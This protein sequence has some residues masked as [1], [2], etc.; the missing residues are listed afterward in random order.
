MPTKYTLYT[1][2]QTYDKIEIPVI[3]RDYAQGRKEQ[4]TLRNKFVDYLLS[5]L[6]EHTAIELDFVYGEERHD[7]AKDG[8]T[9]VTTFIP[10]DGQQR[11]TTLWL[12]HWFLAVKEERLVE[13]H[14]ILS[15]FTYETRPTAH[16]F[17]HHLTTESFP[18]DRMADID[19]FIK[20]C[21]WFD[22]E[23]MNDSSIRGMLRMLQTFASSPLIN[24][25]E[26]CLD[27]LLEPNDLISFYFVPLQNF[28]QAEEL[29]IR[30]NARGKILTQFENFKSEFYKILKKNPRL[31]E[32]KDKM[33][34]AWVSN[35]WNYRKPNV[36]VTDECFMNYLQFITR[37][38]Y[39]KQA[40]YRSDNGYVSNFVDFKL[41]NNI[42]SEQENTEFLIF[43]IDNI[44][45][46]SSQKDFPVLWT[47]KGEKMPFSDIL[48]ICI[49]GG[50]MSIEH[51]F[52]LYAA[53]VYAYKHQK[54]MI[55]NGKGVFY[56]QMNDF[57]RVIR[58][59]IVNTN[60]KSEREHPRIISSI[61]ELC[62]TDNFY[63]AIR[64]NGF[65]L[66]G[67]NDSQCAEENV[68]AK[69]IQKHPSSKSLIYK[70]EDDPCFKGNAMN[71]IASVYGD[72]EDQ[73]KNFAFQEPYIDLF[74]E[75]KLENV[76]ESYKQ[77]AKDNFYAVWGDL[78]DTSFYTHH[79]S[80][81]RLIYDQKYTKSPAVIALAAKFASSEFDSLDDF[82]IY[83]EKEFIHKVSSTY[84]DFGQVRDVKTQLRLLYI[85]C[86]RILKDCTIENFFA[87]GCYNFGWLEKETGFTSLFT[88]GI[89]NDPWFSENNPI[90]QTY[91]S[92]FRYNMGLSKEH[93]LPCEIVGNGRPQKAWDKLQ[94]WA[95][96]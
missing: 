38:L 66:K 63:E 96:A 73:I 67:F 76:Y 88:Q 65:N 72:T 7:M 51:L 24:T 33:E 86:I 79:A 35:L 4:G 6:K 34:Y 29:Y 45:F 94:D 14:S 62:E 17:C 1:L 75:Q 43:A 42:Y 82:L 85:L 27:L 93:A 15:K 41:L 74:D 53:L 71:I 40:E 10:I 83:E 95:N 28:G 50:H 60:D 91:N 64:K 21:K 61:I 16:D 3:Q 80:W 78:L 89:D 8:N 58:N 87:S 5:A 30:M 26:I 11:L 36:Y 92:Q 25:G 52:V 18:K 70:I 47:N 48:S 49:R 57:V 56:E 32:V 37:M 81:G 84:G 31:D 39:F 77:L 9:K 19:T 46:L 55:E 12:L 22:P 13:I 59:L 2:C 44:P 68:K 54:Q 23:W 90:F 20:D 69:I